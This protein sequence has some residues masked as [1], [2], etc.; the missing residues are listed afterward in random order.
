MKRFLLITAV[1]V[2]FAASVFAADAT[3]TFVSGKV[4]VQRGGKWVALQKGDTVSKS[5]TIS[6]GFQSEAK[7]KLM[8][9]VLYLGP[10]TRVTLE[11][12]STVDQ[13]D[14]VNVYLKTGTTRS[15]VRH[16]DNKRVNYQVHTAVAVASCR[17]TDWIADDSNNFD[18]IDGEFLVGMYNEAAP[19]VADSADAKGTLVR[20]GQSA[21]VTE[22]GVS[23]TVSDVEKTASNVTGAVGTAS[24]KEGVGGTGFVVTTTPDDNDTGFVAVISDDTEDSETASVVVTLEIP[25]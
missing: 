24:S 3:V 16:V 4:E 12:L 18:G 21:K 25:D 9:S 20:G 1:F 15:Q 19:I 11:E 17:G 2:A 23:A 8:E 10:V 14:N 7:I 5:E 6:T 22:D 13:T